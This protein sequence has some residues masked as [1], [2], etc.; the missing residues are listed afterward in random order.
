MDEHMPE[1]RIPIEELEDR[2]IYIIRSRNLAV[3]AWSVERRGFIGIREKFHHEYLF[4]EYEWS[5]SPT[6]GTAFATEKTEHVIPDD[7]PLT[8]HLQD[9]AGEFIKSAEG[10]IQSNGP[11]FDILKPLDVA[12]REKR[13]KEWDL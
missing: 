1:G 6:S 2:R 5:T 11:L 7:I 4:T 12:E 13:R 8:E 3:G 9:E 10:Y